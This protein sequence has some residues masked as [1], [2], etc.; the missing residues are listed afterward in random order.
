MTVS[1]SPALEAADAPAIE[2]H[3]RRFLR[4]DQGGQQGGGGQGGGAQPQDPP[5]L[6][7]MFTVDDKGGYFDLTDVASIV[8]ENAGALAAG[9][10]FIGVNNQ[11]AGSSQNM[12]FAYGCKWGDNQAYWDVSSGRP[13]RS[14]VPQ[15][16]P[17]ISV[18][19][20]YGTVFSHV[21]T[22]PDSNVDCGFMREHKPPNLQFS[23]GNDKVYATPFPT[24]AGTIET[25]NP[26]NDGEPH[27]F[28]INYL[29]SNG[30]AEFFLDGVSQGT[31]APDP[32]GTETLDQVSMV[33]GDREGL[34]QDTWR[35]FGRCR[36]GTADDVAKLHA[37]LMAPGMKRDG[38]AL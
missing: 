24:T 25:I 19:Y 14:F 21:S 26:C 23:A 2:P 35:V 20:L 37:L 3:Q 30:Y 38:V 15:P 36:G 6:S 34:L 7:E 32:F 5:D 10:M 27:T 12:S 8:H 28:I 18:G 29:P 31:L 16:R 1:F 4:R 9:D 17:L 22:A 13:M 11:R 33:C